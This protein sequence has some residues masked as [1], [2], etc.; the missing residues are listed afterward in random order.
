[1]QLATNDLFAWMV[2][3]FGSAAVLIWFTRRPDKPAS[4]AAAH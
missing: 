3:I 2:P 4:P 1:V